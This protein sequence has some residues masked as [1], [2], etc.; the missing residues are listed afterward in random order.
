MTQ[1]HSDGANNVHGEVMKALCSKIG[2]VK[3]KSSRLHPQG[4]GMAE[5]VVKM[6]KNA[7]SKQVDQHGSDW[8]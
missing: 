3:S 8:D 7:I 1:L 6:L 4:D 2:S 5:A